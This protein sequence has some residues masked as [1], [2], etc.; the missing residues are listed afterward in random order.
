[1]RKVFAILDI[2]TVTDARLA[3]DVA[4]ILY[5]SK[6][7][8]IERYN[9]LVSEIANAPFGITLISR[10]SFMKNKSKY[11]RDAITFHGIPVK[12]FAEIAA[13]FAAISD[14]YNARTVMCAYNASF[15][16]NVLNANANMYYGENFF[17]ADV[18]TVDIMT[19]C[20]ATFCDTNKFVR[21]AMLNGFTTDKG[22]IKTSAETVF[23]YVS[24]D[25]DFAE[26]HHALADCEIESVLY[27]KAR[28]WKEKHHKNFA[29]PVFNC[30][31]WKAVQARK[32]NL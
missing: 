19:M 10:D 32:N 31:E 24:R 9:A 28:S 18:E 27:F 4:W 25:N 11:Y 20:L 16:F 17:S 29:N 22:N 7:N 23:A 15:D 12:S 14:K 6:G 2:E 3:F 1:M 30:A 13:D 26:A 5:D 21:W 8:E